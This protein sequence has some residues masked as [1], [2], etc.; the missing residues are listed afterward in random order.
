MVGFSRWKSKMVSFSLWMGCL[1][2]IQ[3]ENKQNFLSEIPDS[4]M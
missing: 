2:F 4:R 1:G 3:T